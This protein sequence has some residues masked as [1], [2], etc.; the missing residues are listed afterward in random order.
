MNIAT[1]ILIALSL[2]MDCFAVSVTSG[3]A[4]ARLGLR[5]ALRI[6]LFFGFFQALMPIIGWLA[7]VG[8][9][10]FISEIDHW[11]AFGLLVAVG[12]KMIYESGRLGASPKSE[13]PPNFYS[14][15]VLSIATSIDALALGISLSLLET[16]IITPAIV[17]GATTF[18]LS[19]IGT[20]VGK[21]MGHFF[22]RSIELAGGFILI[23]IGVKILVEHLDF[24]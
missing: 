18:V 17:I 12:G 10:G 19:F 4:V 24:I 16:A 13:N 2:S 15:I 21:T 9:K 3:S 1:I 23:G 8:L 5:H 20:Y 6:A 11:V 14:L 7:G 22:E